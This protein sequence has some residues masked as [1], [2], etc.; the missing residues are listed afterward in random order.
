[1][2][3]FD[4][5]RAACVGRWGEP[6]HTQ[7]HDILRAWRCDWDPSDDALIE[8]ECVG[9]V[10]LRVWMGDDAARWTLADAHGDSR[11]TPLPDALD[12][13]ERWLRERGVAMPAGAR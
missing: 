9:G 10:W 2:T 12:A 5:A 13:A 4:D 8:L 11:I 7:S 3:A 6:A 1:M